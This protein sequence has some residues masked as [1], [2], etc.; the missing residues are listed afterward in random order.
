MLSFDLTIKME[1]ILA[2]LTIIIGGLVAFVAYSQFILARD[3][4]KLDLFEKR[5]AIYKGVQ[6]FLTDIMKE[7]KVTIER[8]FQYRAETQ[9]SMFLFDGKIAEYLKEIDEKALNLYAIALER[10]DMPKGDQGSSLA[11]E[12]SE[13]LR[14][15][16]SQLPKLKDIFSP[17][18]KFKTWK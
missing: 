9:D 10:S 11:K 18:L 2:I 15:L 13:L 5:F 17:Y 16:I 1:H 3:K 12:E 14:W 4:F 7:A 8:L 6:S